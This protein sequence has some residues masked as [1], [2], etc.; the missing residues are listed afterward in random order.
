[1][2]ILLEH[3]KKLTPDGFE[4][5]CAD[6]LRALDF[7]NVRRLGGSGDKG[8]D[9]LCEREIDYGAGLSDRFAWVVQCKHYPQG[10]SKGVLL[11]DLAAA[12]EHRFD[13]WWLMTSA[14]LSPAT[15]DWLHAAGRRDFPFRIDYLDRAKIDPIVSRFPSLVSTY[16]PDALTTSLLAIKKAMDLM[17]DELYREA[18]DLLTGADVDL[19]PHA[20]YLLA[21]SYSRLAG[22]SGP[23]K[24]DLLADAFASLETA[25]KRGLLAYFEETRAWP[26][27]KS[28][29]EIHE[30]PDLAA[31]LQAD[32]ERF[33]A[34][35][36][37][38][39][40]E[41]G[42]CFPADTMIE[43]RDGGL[44]PIAWIRPGDRVLAV[45]SKDQRVDSEVVAVH[46]S[47]AVV[48]VEVN[49]RLRTSL[50][51]RLHRG[52]DWLPAARVAPGDL[53]TTASGPELVTAT[54]KNTVAKTQ[55][56]ELILDG[57][58]SF[59][60]EGYLVHNKKV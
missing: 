17:T 43:L 55:V 6:L 2:P 9:L 57:P 50:R 31:L 39:S 26:A 16:F 27:A 32:R 11:N 49:H 44:L 40:L 7:K 5:L 22:G 4:A 29:A 23:N 15:V 28:L 54:V 60:A 38:S 58:P 21:C 41:R 52:T 30:D 13:I 25:E 59:Y 18:I 10:L 20:S 35:F 19:N 36:P 46:R 47:H 34:I 12:K 37:E 24:A 3:W 8:R 14:Q 51:Q 42:G 56:Y 1:M 53:V 45:Q 33:E 48:L